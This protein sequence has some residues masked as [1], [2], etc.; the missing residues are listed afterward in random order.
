MSR[1]QI[2]FSNLIIRR[3]NIQ[4]LNKAIKNAVIYSFALLASSILIVPIVPLYYIEPW[5]V[6]V[7]FLPFIIFGLFAVIYNLGRLLDFFP[8]Q[9]INTHTWVAIYMDGNIGWADIGTQN[10]Y[11]VLEVLHINRNFRKKGIG[12]LLVQTLAEN[13]I[14]PLYVHS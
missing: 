13:E 7:A 12:T 4:D 3:A 6:V 5:I 1:F 11:S 14:K 9:P 8:K 10:N 2:D